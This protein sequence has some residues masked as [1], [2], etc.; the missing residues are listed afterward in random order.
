MSSP[1]ILMLGLLA[2]LLV[3][4]AGAL[5][6]GVRP[7]LK[8]VGGARALS[9]G[10]PMMVLRGGAGRKPRAQAAA[11]TCMSLAGTWTDYVALLEEKPIRTKMAT[12]AVLSA[13]GDLLAQTLDAAVTSFC[14]R[15]M[16]VLVFINIIY[17]APMLHYW[18]IFFDYVVG[19]Q[20]KLK[21]GTMK[22]TA[23]YLALDQLMNA[24]VTLLGFFA[25]FTLINAISEVAVGVPF[26]GLAALAA[27]VSAKV[28]GSYVTA[29]V[30]NWK[31]WTAPQLL[32]FAVVP[33]PLRVPFANV[34][35][36]L[37]NAVISVIANK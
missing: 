24:P 14:P 9:V 26:P 30:A 8:H 34:V 20:L 31:V 6:T 19:K 17:F 36:I 5:T 16:L 23:A 7:M 33:A 37:W 27:T 22:S 21:A 10:A 12:A 35:A 4:P 1:R 32:N 29:L 2:C 25:I 15:R 13:I 3:V 28:Q 11:L 18:Y